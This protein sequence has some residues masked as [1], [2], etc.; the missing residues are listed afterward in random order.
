MLG[1]S[2][3]ILLGLLALLFSGMWVAAACG[4][5]GVILFYVHLG[6][7]SVVAISNTI[8][9][10]AVNFSLCTVPLFVFLGFLLMESGLAKRVYAGVEP[11]LNHFPGGLLHTNIIVGA[12]FASASGSSLA[13]AAAIGSIAL[14]EMEKRGYPRELSLGS[15]AGGG[16]LAI[17]IP[18]SIIMIMYCII[19]GQS[20][21]KQFIAGIFPGLCLAGLFMLYIALRFQIFGRW[22]E[23]RGE[24]LPWI[25][26][27]ART[28]SVWLIVVLV[29]LVLGSIYLGVATP[30]EA[31]GVGCVGAILLAWMHRSF[32]W[33]VLKKTTISTVR[34]TSALLFILIGTH[35]LSSAL[36]F[37]GVI[38][39]ITQG[40]TSAPVPP[41]VILI[42]IYVFFIVLSMFI[43]SLPLVLIMVP[44]VFPAVMALGYDP[45]WFGIVVV[46]L[47]NTGQLSPPVGVVLFV[48]Q[49]LE[50]DRP[51]GEL[52]RGVMPFVLIIIVMLVIITAFPQIALWLPGTMYG[53]R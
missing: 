34:L 32:N 23:V 12:L 19:T 45:I 51:L 9:T 29:M 46:L 53:V 6:P 14:P 43:E 2:I 28:R 13:S 47:S 31:A 15:V 42:I 30:V 8:W 25:P 22:Q 11:F 20:I 49:S 27:I 48:L 50:P 18:P 10:T 4:V 21:G 26:S 44:M 36:G 52:Y 24:V 1:L 16:T 39:Y 41:I 5:I 38:R 7:A 40:L 17:L 37:S 3:G 33:Q 35:I